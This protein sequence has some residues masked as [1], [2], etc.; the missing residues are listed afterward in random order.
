LHGKQPH[1]VGTYAYVLGLDAL[2]GG[3]VACEPQPCVVKADSL[4]LDP[5]VAVEAAEVRNERLDDEGAAVGK[6][7]GDVLEAVDLCLLCLQGEERAEDDIDQRELAL[8]CYVGEVA[9]VDRDAVSAWLR[10]KARD[11]LL[12]GVDPPHVDAALGKRE[13]DTS[14]SNCELKHRAGGGELGQ[15]GDR[16][17]RD[18]PPPR[19]RSG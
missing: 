13:R 18:R 8:D 10:A 9:D 19:L 7:R 14:R 16:C 4:G 12:R 1:A 17:S 5:L 11:H 6:V 3:I 15:E 2:L